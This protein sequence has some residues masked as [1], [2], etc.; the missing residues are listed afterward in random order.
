MGSLVAVL[1]KHFP[2]DL[3]LSASGRGLVFEDHA[4]R[5]KIIWWA[6]ARQCVTAPNS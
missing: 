5:M 2:A 3:L 1:C 4:L 6:T